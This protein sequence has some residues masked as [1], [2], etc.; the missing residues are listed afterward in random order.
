MYYKIKITSSNEEFAITTKALANGWQKTA[1][2]KRKDERRVNFLPTCMLFQTETRDFCVLD[3]E[4]NF[5]NVGIAELFE[6]LERETELLQLYETLEFETLE[7]YPYYI[8]DNKYGKEIV[9]AGRDYLQG[10]ML[11]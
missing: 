5:K 2:Q 1:W 10:N 11:H 6:I 9:D 3:Y 7:T 8:D 4:P